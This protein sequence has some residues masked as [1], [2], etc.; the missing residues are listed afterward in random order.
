MDMVFASPDE[1]FKLASALI[2]EAC[3]EKTDVIVL[4]ET[5][6]TGFFPKENL[7]SFCDNNGERVKNE[8]GSLAKKYNVN[9]IGGSISNCKNNKIYNTS[10]IFN[11]QGNCIAEY[12]KAHLFTPMGED[13]Y[14]EKGENICRFKLDEINCGIIICY[15]L[16]F[17][18]LIR[19]LSVKGIDFLFVVSQWPI[20]RVN[21]LLA[22][23]K[24]RAI[25]N[26]MFVAC[27]NSCGTA[28]DTTFGGN[29]CIF[30]PLGEEIA[31]A[32]EKSE[33]ITADCD[34][35]VLKNIRETISVFSDRRTDIY[36]L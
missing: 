14:F 23:N 35:S 27:C 2:A 19:S 6:N 5:W 34:T 12:D 8:I 13:K 28:Y 32:G 3:K 15:D 20:A 36:D 10:Y 4:P 30:D 33:I 22:L 26:Q 21:H 24:A 1:N 17:P 7:S 16:R 29:S 9:I 11:R 25:E 18:E 31:H